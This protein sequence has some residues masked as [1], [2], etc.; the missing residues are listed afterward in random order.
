MNF[1]ANDRYPPLCLP[2]KQVTRRSC[3]PFALRLLLRLRVSFA[4]C[5]SAP[6]GSI[7]WML[8]GLSSMRVGACTS[9]PRWTK[10]LVVSLVSARGPEGRR[11]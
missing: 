10:A 11:R 2:T 1:F 9:L 5:E 8:A 4:T 6:T 7:D 3:R